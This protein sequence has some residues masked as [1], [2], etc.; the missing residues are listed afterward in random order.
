MPAREERLLQSA[1]CDV[2]ACRRW[3]P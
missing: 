1:V 2:I 3:S